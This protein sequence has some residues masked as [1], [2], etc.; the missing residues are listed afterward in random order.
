MGQAKFGGSAA[1]T[2]AGL[3]IFPGDGRKNSP[4]RQP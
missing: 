2:E 4:F 1:L 3:R